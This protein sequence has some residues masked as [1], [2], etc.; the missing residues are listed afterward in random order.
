MC[1]C[2]CACVR[3]RESERERVGGWVLRE[4]LVTNGVCDDRDHLRG[5]L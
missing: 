4:D 1:L 3:V 2:V 5:E